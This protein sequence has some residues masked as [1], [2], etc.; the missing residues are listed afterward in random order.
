[1]LTSVASMTSITSITSML[2]IGLTAGSAILS[3]VLIVAL[4]T[5]ELT[6]TTSGDHRLIDSVNAVLVPLAFAFAVIVI[7]QTTAV[8]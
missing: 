3:V 6:V 4:V 2:A 8:V 1:M 7:L 5:K